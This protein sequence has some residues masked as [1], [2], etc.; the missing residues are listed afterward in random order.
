MSITNLASPGASHIHHLVVT[1]DD[2]AHFTQNW[3]WR[4]NG[5]DQSGAFRFTRKKSS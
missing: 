3:T 1:F 2:H 5:K 4:E